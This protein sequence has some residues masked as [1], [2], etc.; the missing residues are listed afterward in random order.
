MIHEAAQEQS[1][2]KKLSETAGSSFVESYSPVPRKRRGN[3]RA[4]SSSTGADQAEPRL[5]GLV[6]GKPDE[7]Q[8][9]QEED[10]R[11]RWMKEQ[12]PPHW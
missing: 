9:G 4:S 6:S 5:A 1:G 8:G 11:A 7:R 3:R 10:A 2:Q 12:R